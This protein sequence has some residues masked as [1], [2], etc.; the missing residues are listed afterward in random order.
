MARLLFVLLLG[1]VGAKAAIYI[2]VTGADVKKAKLAIGQVHPLPD[3]QYPDPKLAHE[4]HTQVR[5]DLEFTNLFEFVSDAS[6][7]HLD[8]PKKVYSVS[9]D[10]WTP[11]GAAFLLKLGYKVQAGKLTLEGLLFDI[12]G[13]KK[14]FA[15]RYQYPVQQYVRLVHTL[16]DDILKALTGERGLFLSRV[17]MIC[18]E[19]R[20]KMI[21]PKE[22][23]IS[24]V[25]GKNV[26]RLTS[27]GTLSLSPS[28]APDGKHISYTQYEARGR[29]RGTALKWHNLSTGNRKIISAK[30][31]MNS[32]AA[33]APNGRKI[34][35]TLSFSGRP[36]IYFLNPWTDGPPEPFSRNIQ[37]KRISGEGYQPSLASLLFD[38]EPSWSPDN[39]K[40]VFSSA[41]SGNPMIY[42]ADLASKVAQQ[43]T[44]A[45]KYNATPAWSPRGDKILFAAQRIVE[46][47]F[48]IYM[49]DPDG[50]NLAR[51]T[52][53]DRA[54]GRKV[55]SEN[56]TWAPTGRHFAFQSNE[57]GN[58]AIYVTTLD[59][60]VKRRIS[61]TDK[62][63]TSPAWGPPEG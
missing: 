40:I 37:V 48:D 24:D 35:A 32:G 31:G 29:K 50:N 58:Y 8:H 51:I 22:V 47:N 55:N 59:G 6:F 56:P 12:P 25:D 62:E 16:A 21:T 34:A 45:G 2:T 61:P 15:T 30:E 9:F 4:I 26:F 60:S 19:L 18:K 5:S 53:G 14:I 63:C 28:W 36:E 39:T 11:T 44:F 23:Y 43:L 13:R 57:G 17:L 38:V 33:W 46:G 49:I 20:R 1:S 41:R 52:S 7:Y 10:E 27:D 42:T 3:F 54:T